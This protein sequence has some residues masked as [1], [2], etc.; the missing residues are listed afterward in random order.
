MEDRI[1]EF[2]IRRVFTNE[3]REK[4]CADLFLLSSGKQNAL[5]NCRRA[6]VQA[7]HTPNLLLIFNGVLALRWTV[8]RERGERINT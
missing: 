4:F 6:Q 7:S 5:N 1:A 2:D 8:W 3:K